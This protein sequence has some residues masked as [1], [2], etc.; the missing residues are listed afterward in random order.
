MW[1]WAHMR[2]VLFGDELGFQFDFHNS[3]FLL[4]F[5]VVGTMIYASFYLI[6]KDRISSTISLYKL[7]FNT[8]EDLKTI[9]GKSRIQK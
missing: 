3:C 5:E 6:N 1:G 2:E 9:L 4:S 8:I 7:H